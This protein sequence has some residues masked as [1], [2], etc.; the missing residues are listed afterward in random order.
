MRAMQITTRYAEVTANGKKYDYADGLG[1][2]RLPAPKYEHES[3]RFVFPL[4]GGTENQAK[5]IAKR[6]WEQA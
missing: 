1:E 2:E 6:L 5:A 4:P 3:K